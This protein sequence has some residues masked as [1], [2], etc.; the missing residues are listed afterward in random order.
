ML[1]LENKNSPTRI[2]ERVLATL[3]VVEHWFESIALPGFEPG[4]QP[5]SFFLK[6]EIKS[7]KHFTFK[8]LYT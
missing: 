7:A 5:F 2:P 8:G 3:A 6:R 4:S 1:K